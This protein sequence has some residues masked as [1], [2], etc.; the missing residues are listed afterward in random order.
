MRKAKLNH[1]IPELE[2]VPGGRLEF[3]WDD[4][5][6][7]INNCSI[8][9]NFSKFIQNKS[10]ILVGPSPYMT[11]HERGN[12]IDSHDIVIRMNK[13]FPIL[14]EHFK[15]IGSKTDVRWHCMNTYPRHG[16]PYFIK[17]M[18]EKNVKW[19]CSQFP[20]NL[21]YFHNDHLAI[22]NQNKSNINFHTWTDLEQY[23]TYHH[24]LGTRMNTGTACVLDLLNYDFKSL[25]ITGITFF[26]EGWIDGYKEKDYKATEDKSIQFGNHA[27]APQIKLFRLIYKNNSNVTF[28][29][30][31][32]KIITE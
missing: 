32:I 2:R 15:Y 27:M 31:I 29:D 4:I 25:H 23:L 26:R 28:D 9:K 24:F 21:D 18:K 5:Q 20:N 11:N 7:L 17:E 12:W 30:E 16:G 3:E 14:K 13:S 22:E 19:L 6:Y 1:I 10:I 8:D